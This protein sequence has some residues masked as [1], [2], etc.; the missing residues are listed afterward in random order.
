MLWYCRL[1]CK[2]GAEGNKMQKRDEFQPHFYWTQVSVLEDL[3]L[4]QVPS[5]QKAGIHVLITKHRV[6]S[7]RTQGIKDEGA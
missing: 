2:L 4:K 3:Q 1:E 5:C 6:R 7:E